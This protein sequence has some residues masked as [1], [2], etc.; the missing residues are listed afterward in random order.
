MTLLLRNFRWAVKK[1]TLPK[2]L[3]H[4][5]GKNFLHHEE[6]FK[7]VIQ[8]PKSEREQSL[9]SESNGRNVGHSGPIGLGT[10]IRSARA[11]EEEV[12]KIAPPQSTRTDTD[13]D[14]SSQVY[15]QVLE[16]AV[17]D[18]EFDQE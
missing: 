1:Y 18:F 6:R 16:D 15:H 2:L 10:V 11:A 8:D 17:S 14:K 7:C 5:V 13:S 4:P 12:K 9:G 3:C